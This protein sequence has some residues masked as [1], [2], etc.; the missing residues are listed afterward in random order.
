MANQ[1]PL[2]EEIYM[3]RRVAALVILLVV[4]SLVIWG[5][6]AMAK[7]DGGDG[8]TST[9]ETSELVTEPTVSEPSEPS[10]PSGTT[11]ETSTASTSTTTATTTA[12]TTEPVAAAKKGSCELSDLRI[13]AVPPQPSFPVN[14]QPEFFMNVSNPTDGDCELDLKDG[15][16]R[17]EVYEMATNKRVWADTDC[18]PSIV[19]GRQVFPAGSEQGFKAVWSVT[20]SQ[21]G[22]CANRQQVPAGAYYLHGV[23]GDNASDP[24]PFNLTS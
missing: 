6:S 24:A 16:V 10:E 11:T 4:A 1:R 8:P 2:P 14:S 20:A 22:Q 17:F 19:T 12:T 18:Y 5:L 3:R 9:E 15:M 7:S 23:I 13:E 21:P